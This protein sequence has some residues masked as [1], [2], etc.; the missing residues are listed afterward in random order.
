MVEEMEMVLLLQV[1][2]LVQVMMLVLKS[3]VELVRYSLEL[4]M[5]MRKLVR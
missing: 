4:R 5:L 2:R 3:Q 1:G